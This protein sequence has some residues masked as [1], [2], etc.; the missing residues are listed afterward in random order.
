MRAWNGLVAVAA[1]F[2]LP[3]AEP[4]PDYA[5]DAQALD[6]LIA[7]NYA[8]I[9]RF[10]AAKLPDSSLLAAERDAV[11]DAKSLLAYAERRIAS[12]ADHHAITG[13][14]FADSWAIVPTY[15]DLWIVA[16]EGAYRID[17]VRADSPAEKAGIRRGDVLVAI[18]GVPTAQAVADFWAGLGLD[19][20][21]D[22]RDGYAARVLAAGRRD[23]ERRLTLSRGHGKA[24]MVMLPNLYAVEKPESAPV[25][26]S[27]E[28]ADVTAIRLNNALGDDRTVEAFDAAMASL[29][30]DAR[31]VIDLRDTPSG[32]NS[33][34][35]RGI[36]GWFVDRPT[37]YQMHSLPAEEA[38]SGIARQWIELVLPRAGKHR[39]KPVAVRVGR[40]TGSMGEG[41]AIGFASMGVPVCGERMAGLRG[42]IHDF[43]LPSSRMRFKIP[44]ERLFTVNGQ[45]REDFRPVPNEDC[46]VR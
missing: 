5:G 18:E 20:A 14:S 39:A 1:L 21:V 17:A 37:P 44:V 40:W 4:A 13:A 42:A 12:L 29:P 31:V 38:S 10:A 36:M 2:L 22:D 24:R 28:G 33:M 30:A 6:A 43:D 11:R 8:Y 32:G 9:D 46:P 3:A 16:D 19:V 7:E 25:A 26:V 15:A 27:M 34:V 41:I 23:R 45:P 35:A